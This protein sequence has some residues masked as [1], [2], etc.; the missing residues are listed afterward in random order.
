MTYRILSLNGVLGY[1]FPEESL[2]KA[3]QLKIDLIAD[4]CGSMDGGPFYL[5]AG[6]SAFKKPSIKRDFSLVMKAAWQQGCPVVLGS[7]GM[8]GDTPHLQWMV[9]I[10]KEVFAEQGIKGLKVAVVESHLEPALIINQVHRLKPLGRMPPLTKKAVQESAIVAAMGIAPY[11]TAL[12]NGAQVVLCGRSCDVAIFAADPVRRAM[13]PG[14]AYQ[15][16]HILECGAIACHPG[17]GSDC[18]MAEFRDNDRVVFTPP[19]EARKATAYSIAAHSLYEE[20]HPVLQRYPEGTLVMA[21][22][23]YFEELP[24]SAGIRNTKFVRTPLSVKLEG[25][26]KIGERMVSFVSLRKEAAQSGDPILDQ[27]LVYGLNAVERRRL[28]PEEVEIGILMV[29]RGAEEEAVAALASAIKGFMFHYGYPGRITTAG[30]LSHPLS[31]LELVYENPAGGFTGLVIAGTR[32][33]RFIEQAEKIFTAVIKLG[34]EQYPELMAKC[35]VEFIISDRGHPLM[36]LDT[37]AKTPAEAVRLH[38]EELRKIEPYVD[39]GHPSFYRVSG[40]EVYEWSI[41][42]LWDDEEAIKKYLF[43]IKIYEAKGR[44]WKLLNEIRPVYRDIGLTDYPGNIDEK[45]LNRI[46]KVPHEGEPAGYRPLVEMTRVLRS[47][48]AGVNSITYDIFFQTA[49]DYRQ[50]LESNLFTPEAVAKVLGVPEEHII[51]TY[52]CNPCY[53]I[54]VSRY[55]EMIAGTPGSP[56][57]FGAQQQMRL[58]LLQIPIYATVRKT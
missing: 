24:R 38:E 2:E 11:I 52:Y 47:K 41:Y 7:C 1:S 15:A 25:S 18:L 35:Q 37:V 55:R 43:P 40:G 57:T 56:D 27:Y 42:H 54:K 19:N 10:V 39:P 44:D 34:Q 28:L 58:E 51:G 29:F 49:E 3:M 53:A 12:E 32:E 23:E 13:N 48:D 6:V 22:T 14:L 16:G 5:G 31:P 33:P 45:T 26:R 30:N 20:T 21:E 50:A 46:E 36:L 8:A 17:S 9:E 4:D